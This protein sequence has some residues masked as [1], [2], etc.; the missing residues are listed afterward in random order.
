[1]ARRSASNFYFTF[2]LLPAG[3]R[4]AMFALYA[5]LRHTDDLS[6][7]HQPADQRSMALRRWRTSLDQALQG[8]GQG[9]FDSPFLPA[10]ADTVAR[11]EIQPGHL[12]AVIDGVEQ[13][14]STRRYETFAELQGYC[15][16]V[17]SAVGLACIQVWGFRGIEAF[18]PARQCG[19]AFQLTNILRDLKEDADRGRV[20]LPAEDFRRFDYSP[21]ELARQVRDERLR[22]LVRFQI[23]RTEEFYEQ[24]RELGRWLEPGGRRIFEAMHGAYRQLLAEI[25]RRDGDLFHKRVRL[26]RWRKLRVTL[27]ALK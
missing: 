17:A 3:Q 6:D 23:A 14:L 13:D 26:S 21:D 22:A 24:G 1:M 19:V 15:H 12:H 2:F 25:Q 10:L 18:E 7:A 27:A 11:Y 5:F 9:Q 8:Q 16:Q 4:R 20:Y